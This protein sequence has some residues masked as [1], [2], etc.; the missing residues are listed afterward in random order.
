[1][2]EDPDAVIKAIAEALG[3][4]PST[5]KLDDICETEDGDVVIEFENPEDAEIP[6]NFTE[7]FADAL[8]KYDPV[9]ADLVVSN[10]GNENFFTKSRFEIDSLIS[11]SFLKVLGTKFTTFKDT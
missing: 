3:I 6:S 9:F 4:P 2:K 1:M 8:G 5:I 7:Q 10:P 11:R